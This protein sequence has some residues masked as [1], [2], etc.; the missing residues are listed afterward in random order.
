VFFSH[1]QSSF[2]KALQ[3]FY[4]FLHWVI[5]LGESL[6]F[7]PPCIFCLSIPCQMYRWQRFSPIM[8]VASSF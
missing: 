3:C 6:V 7:W 1:L 4:K 5:N 2:E 8:W